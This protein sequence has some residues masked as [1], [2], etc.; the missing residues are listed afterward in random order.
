LVASTMT[1]RT[2]RCSSP[3]TSRSTRSSTTS[4][5][6]T[7]AR[8]FN[9]RRSLP[10]FLPTHNNIECA[11]K[12]AR[13]LARLSTLASIHAHGSHAPSRQQFTPLQRLFISH[14]HTT[15][16]T[17]SNNNP[18]AKCTSLYHHKCTSNTHAQFPT[19]HTH[20]PTRY[21]RSRSQFR[22]HVDSKTTDNNLT[23]TPT[24]TSTHRHL[25]SQLVTAALDSSALPEELVG[26]IHEQRVKFRAS[27]CCARRLEMSHYFVFLMFFPSCLMF[28]PP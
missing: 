3:T 9:Y 25:L 6:G 18:D 27:R 11:R 5:C 2:S 13:K 24:T 4:E 7:T 22:T 16:G 26:K 14:T 8:R 19:I 23:T 21:E 20:A 28:F 10:R 15:V 1:T 17:P 12:R